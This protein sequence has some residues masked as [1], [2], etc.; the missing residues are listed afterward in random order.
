MEIII[1]IIMYFLSNMIISNMNKNNNEIEEDSKPEEVGIFLEEIKGQ[2][3]AWYL[4]PKDQ[5]I[6]QA[7][8]VDQLMEELTK[9][10]KNKKLHIVT[11]EEIKW[12]LEKQITN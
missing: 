12:H 3:Y 10:F 9:I 6:V 2:Y 4:E 8:T 11:T 5:F 7:K 1:A